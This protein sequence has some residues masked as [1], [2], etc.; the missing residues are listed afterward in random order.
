[1]C[2]RA[3]ETYTAEELDLRYMNQR[4]RRKPFAITPNWNL[5]PTQLAPVLFINNGER[6]FAMMRF[7]L[8]PAWAKSVKDAGKYSL[9]NAKGEE[10]ET[11]RSYSQAFQRRRCILPVS[12]FYEW[13]RDGKLKRP[14]AIHFKNNRIISI[15]AVWEHWKSGETGEVVDS[16]AVITT[17]PNSFMES[18]HNRMPV[19]L[20]EKDENSWLDQATDMKAAKALLKPCPSEWLEAHEVSTL[21]NSPKNNGPLCIEPLSKA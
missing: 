20:D 2:G 14:F 1:M 13:K 16:F 17:G 15:A 11:K 12:G 9:I 6:V 7:G 4:I 10:I 18:I 3:Y 19:I 5:A 21:V 8:V